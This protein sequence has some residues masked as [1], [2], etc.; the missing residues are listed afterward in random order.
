MSFPKLVK[1]KSLGQYKIFASYSDGSEGAIDLSYLKDQ[2]IFSKW[3]VSD[4]FNQVHIDDFTNAIT[5]GDEI[6]ICPNNLYLKLK[7]INF[8]EFKQQMSSLK[9]ATNQ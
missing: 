1:V 7:N 5:W 6:E 8:D 4:F 2:P 3:A 9:Y